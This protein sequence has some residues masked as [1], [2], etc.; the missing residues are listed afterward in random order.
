[1]ISG[2]GLNP[3]RRAV[4]PEP[5][6]RR[7]NKAAIGP[8][9][10][11]ALLIYVYLLFFFSGCAKEV[12]IY[13]PADLPVS[14]VVAQL[15]QR[16]NNISSFRA[17]GTIRVQG[18]KQRWSG[19]AFLLGELPDSLRL[20]VVGLFGNPVL[21]A[22]SDGQKFTIW[23]PGREHAYQGLA[24]SGTLAR[25]IKFPL[26]DR[27]A[28]LLLAGIVPPWHQVRAKLFRLSESESFMLQLESKATRLR[29]RIWLKGEDL[30]VTRIERVHGNEGTFE[31]EF[32]DFVS[33]DG[34]FYPR[35]IVMEGG[36]AHLSIRYQ[37]F[38]INEDLD[39]SVFHLALP[40]GIEIVPW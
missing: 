4:G 1:V 11:A 9:R 27:E 21:Y 34:A 36:R 26:R 22:A 35:S 3:D 28:L 29:Q 33:I 37:Q 39:A 19:R 38:A 16:Q 13:E 23:E 18:G 14:L 20:E 25:L 40:E 15:E 6:R 31:A 10:L 17:V 30:M 12:L 5:E 32:S 7:L 24:S 8:L 2:P